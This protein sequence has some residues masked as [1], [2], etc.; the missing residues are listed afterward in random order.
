MKDNDPFG[1]ISIDLSSDEKVMHGVVIC[2][3]L[4]S[5]KQNVM[6]QFLECE[7]KW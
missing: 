4:G 5:L 2:H 7:E 1:K 6:L 3:D